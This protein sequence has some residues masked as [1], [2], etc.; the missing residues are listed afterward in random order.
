LITPDPEFSD[1]NKIGMWENDTTDGVEVFYNTT[2][3][4]TDTTSLEVV[5][6]KE[7]NATILLNFDYPYKVPPTVFAGEWS[8]FIKVDVDP[9]NPPPLSEASFTVMTAFSYETIKETKVKPASLGY[10]IKM[11]N[12]SQWSNR[13]WHES[14]STNPNLYASYG[15]DPARA[16]FTRPRTYGLQFNIGFKGNATALG[17]PKFHIDNAKFMLYGNSFGLLGTDQL[18][19]D[20]FTQ[21]VVGTRI[22]FAIGLISATVSILIGLVIG[23]IAGYVGGATDEILMRF[24]DMLLVIPTLPLL[25]VLVF[26][27]GQTMLNIIFVVGV[28]GWMG[29][30]RTVRS[31]VLSLKERSFIEAVKSAGGG[32]FYIIGRHIIPN[33]FPLIYVTLAVSVPGAIVSEAALSWLGLGPTDVMS[34]GRVLYEFQRSGAIA[35]GAFQFWYWTLPPGLCIALLSLSFVLIGYALDEILNPR[36]RDR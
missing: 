13:P 6:T 1:A 4:K 16:I 8:W 30:A 3:G 17:N 14:A 9:Q 10:I 21:L 24:T 33:V 26:V 18:A 2:F 35:T 7:G 5:F 36:L 12:V 22:S 19:R 20:I 23:L 32:R 29:F 27:L 31:A 25:I 15:T 34:W 11:P 28:L